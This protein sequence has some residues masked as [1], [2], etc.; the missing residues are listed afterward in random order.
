MSN[1]KTETQPWKSGALLDTIKGL[2]VDE[3]FESLKDVSCEDLRKLCG[4]FG[5]NTEGLAKSIARA[6]GIIK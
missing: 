3:I 2:S 4:L 1:G 5:C 6:R